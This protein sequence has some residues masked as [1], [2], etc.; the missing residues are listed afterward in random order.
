MVYNGKKIYVYWCHDS[1]LILATLVGKILNWTTSI[2]CN[3]ALFRMLGKT[4]RR[5]LP[6]IWWGCVSRTM[7]YTL[8]RFKHDAHRCN[9]F[10]ALDQPNIHDVSSVVLRNLD[11]VRYWRN[12]GSLLW[13]AKLGVVNNWYI[14]K[15]P[16]SLLT[17]VS[18][19][20]SKVPGI[21][22]I[23]LQRNKQITEN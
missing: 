13:A 7:W 22:W 19:K 14:R 2:V 8:A 10:G 3:G 4:T 20:I 17:F 18:Q 16:W 21:F 9:W 12:A 1:G 5:W 6:T 23:H 15:I 11:L